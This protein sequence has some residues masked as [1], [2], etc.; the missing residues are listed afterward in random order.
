MQL[1]AQPNYS[2]EVSQPNPGT[3]KTSSGQECHRIWEPHSTFPS[4]SLDS[5]SETLGYI[6][7]QQL[8]ELAFPEKGDFL[9]RLLS[10]Q[11]VKG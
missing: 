2:K 3:L 6:C 10:E 11:T 9:P 5:W 1:T 8:R 4:L 7:R